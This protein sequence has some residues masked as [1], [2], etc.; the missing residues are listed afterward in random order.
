MDAAAAN[1]ANVDTVGYRRSVP[2]M[3]G[4]QLELADEI[5]RSPGHPATSVPGGGSYLEATYTDPSQG[6]L[7]ATGRPLDVALNG[8]GF[9]AVATPAGTRYTRAGNFQLNANQELVTPQGYP[10]LGQGGPITVAGGFVTIDDIGVVR[11]D[12]AE[13]DQLR[14]VE[15]PEPQ[16]LA[17]QGDT[18]FQA[19][20]PVEATA[21]DAT[22]TAVVHQHLERANVELVEELVQM[23]GI[24]RAF[25]LSARAVAAVDRTLGVA[26]QQIPQQQ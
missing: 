1:I 16:L 21:V 18:L 10:V 23:I 25:D 17:R 22:D 5:A 14:V 8:P 6:G 20:P 4:F 7:Q 11:V 24:Q 3:R 13:V 2:V 12:G 9:F 19:P 15:F 26:V